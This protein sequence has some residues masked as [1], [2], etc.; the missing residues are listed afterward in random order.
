VRVALIA[1]ALLALQDTPQSLANELRALAARVDALA[2]A[3]T[4]DPSGLQAAIDGATDGTTLYLRPN[5][6]YGATRV[7]RSVRLT[8]QASV[9]STARVTAADAAGF[10]IVE[11]TGNLPAFDITASDVTIDAIAIRG[12]VDTHI[13]C[14]ST[15]ATDAELQPTNVTLSRLS[16]DGTAGAK[17]GIG[18]HCRNATI[19]H[20]RIFGYRRVGQ[21]TQAIGGWN[22]PGPYIIR[23][24]YLEAAGENVMFGGAAPAIPGMVPRY[25]QILENHFWKDP[26]WKAFGYTVKNH[27]EF[28]V[29][30]HVLVR[31]NRFEHMWAAGQSYSIMLTPQAQDAA[32]PNCIVADVTIEEN[33]FVNV[34]GGIVIKGR[35]QLGTPCL[36]GSG[37]VVRRNWLP[38]DRTFNGGAAQGWPLFISGEPRDVTIE[39]NT[40]DTNGNQVVFQDGLP[41]FGFRFTGNLVLR[42]G[43]Y[44]FSGWANGTTQ[45]RAVL[46]TTYAPGAVVTGNAFGSFPTASNLPGNLHVAAAAITTT[47][48]YGTGE[49]A[50]YGRPRE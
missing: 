32:N 17:R 15:S 49:F 33:V 7:R 36:Q 18:L 47:D 40:F 29:G 50:G 30:E 28:K 13:Q 25:I 8:T 11:P 5:A 26:A 21:D 42:C 2:R 46:L 20:S 38:V 22:G 39:Q 31:G 35:Q 37:F 34:S 4:V 23:N 48:G 6:V 41:V 14:G 44:G 43:A 10:A 24:N 16:L 3:D 27:L 12:N 1:L 9:A 19:E 45:H